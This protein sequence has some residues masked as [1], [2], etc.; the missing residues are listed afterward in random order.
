MRDGPRALFERLL[1]RGARPSG[2]AGG[3]FAAYARR[4]LL[5]LAAAASSLLLRYLLLPVLGPEEPLLP[6][7]PLVLAA[8][9]GGGAWSG[10]VC[11]VA[12]LVGAW[13]LFMGAPFSFALAPHEL[14][15]LIGAFVAG[16]VIVALCVLLRRL[17]A[18][19]NLAAERQRVIAREFAHRMRNTLTLVLALSRRTFTEGRPLDE[20]AQEFEAR[21]TALAQA[22]AVIL[23]ASGEADL[24]ELVARTLAPFGHP[25][26]AGRLAAAGPP[27]K[28]GAEAATAV[29][30]ALHEL[31]TNATK[32]GAL[33]APDGKVQ[34]EW[35]LDGPDRRDLRLVW[36]ERDGPP[37]SPPRGRGFGSQL[38]ERNLAQA[39]GGTARLTFDPAGVTAEIAA[40]LPARSG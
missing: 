26:G 22:H 24:A 15:G 16:L 28:L 27:V 18:Q 13:H 32:Y 39:L 23:E 36:R 8:T 37:V 1:G 31:A 25:A 6:L 29:A 5:G 30:L 11:L 14:G 40:R 38:I 7:F 19:A 35:R 9:L 4:V 10:V 20:A 21:V 2:G 17:I 33:S 12:G 34:V 3:A